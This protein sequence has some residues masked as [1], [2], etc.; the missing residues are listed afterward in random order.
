MRDFAVPDR[1]DA[2]S[3]SHAVSMLLLAGLA[4]L[5]GYNWVV[6]KVGIADSGPV[7]FAAVRMI[8][9]AAILIV[10]LLLLRRRFKIVEP[11]TVAAIGLFQ[12]AG[13]Q[14][15]IALALRTGEAGKSAVLNYTLPIWVMILGYLFLKE[16]PR[17]GQWLATAVALAGIATMA[18][19]GGKPGSLEPVLYALGA[20]FCWGAGVVINQ[21]LM[22]RHPG[23]IDTLV[24]TTWQ[25]VVGSILLGIAALAV[26][27]EPI[28]WTTGFILAVLYNVGPAT[29]VAFLIW[30][31]LQRRIEANVL[32]L[33]VLIV[34]LVGVIS[35]SI[36]LGERPSV[37]DTIGMVLILAAIA[38]MVLTQPK[39]APAAITIPQDE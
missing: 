16:R 26:P 37:S 10:V 21:A 32:S 11:W 33:I 2:R 36:Q 5:W 31:T 20:S 8:G 35:G 27:E 6:M 22:R 19:V 4:L 30:F 17:T 1:R 9:G 34:P 18:F 39:K 14:G 24:L 7:A 13:A 28:Q 25:M 23:G 3:F 15:L 12:T 38:L 29:A